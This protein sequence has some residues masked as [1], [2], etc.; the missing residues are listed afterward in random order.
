MFKKKY[1]NLF[2]S[3][4]G[5]CVVG[6]LMQLALHQNSC[7]ELTENSAKALFTSPKQF[8]E[9]GFVECEKYI[10]D[11]INKTR[12]SIYVQSYHWTSMPMAKALIEAK[13]RGVQILVLLD[14]SNDANPPE[15]MEILLQYSIP[16]R[17]RRISGISH[18]KVMVLDEQ[19]LITG[20]YNFTKSANERNDENILIVNNKELASQYIKNWNKCN[21][22][23]VTPGSYGDTK[24]RQWDSKVGYRSDKSIY[25]I[26]DYINQAKESIYIAI[27][28]GNMLPDSMVK[29]LEIA[30]KAGLDVKILHQ[31]RSSSEQINYS[32]TLLN[33]RTILGSSKLTTM[34]ID[35][36]LE[37]ILTKDEKSGELLPKKVTKS[38][39]R[40]IKFNRD[41]Q[42]KS[43]QLIPKSQNT[44]YI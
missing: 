38:S 42:V 39:A 28:P 9:I 25:T 44:R 21:Q 19:I 2:L 6:A 16:V 5:G 26:K 36:N 15:A 20:S 31:I 3:F 12:S 29:L 40:Y 4:A 11:L 13:K 18:N 7:I 8:R 17:I 10:V 32:Y 33:I 34:I 27:G 37:I 14:K 24:E 35:G 41:W 22:N 30:H 1:L 23:S 43:K